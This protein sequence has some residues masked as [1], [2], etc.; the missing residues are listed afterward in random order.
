[1]KPYINSI[2]GILFFSLSFSA[3][4]DEDEELTKKEKMARKILNLHEMASD[5]LTKSQEQQVK[6]YMAMGFSRGHA[7]RE[8]LRLESSGEMESD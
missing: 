3:F 6:K 8:V 4:A 7:I 2:I 1:M 5:L